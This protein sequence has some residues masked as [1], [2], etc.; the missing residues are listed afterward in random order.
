MMNK[1]KNM[2]DAVH[3]G[4]VLSEEYLRPLSI[5]QSKL[6]LSMRVAPQ[7]INEIINGKR[8]ISADTALRLSRVIGTTPEFWMS[9]QSSYDLEVEQREHGDQ[10]ARETLPLEAAIGN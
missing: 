10:I 4:E 6:A 9:L 7:R 1:S 3:P 5:S 8:G 2:L